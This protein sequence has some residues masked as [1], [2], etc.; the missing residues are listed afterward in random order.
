MISMT[1]NYV[2]EE[3]SFRD[4]FNNSDL[5]RFHLEL[6]LGFFERMNQMMN[7]NHEIPSAISPRIS[8]KTLVPVFSKGFLQNILLA[9]LSW[10]L[11]GFFL[12][13]V[14]KLLSS[15][16]DFIRSF[17]RDNFRDSS[18][19]FYHDAFRDSSLDS[20][21]NIISYSYRDSYKDSYQNFYRDFCWHFLAMVFPG[22]EQTSSQKLKSC[23]SLKIQSMLMKIYHYTLYTM[24]TT[25]KSFLNT[26]LWFLA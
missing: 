18:Q 15:S 20:F 17:L 9:F 5:F 19:N 14:M 8:S 16:R 13:L 23:F 2:R 22:T 1:I 26:V 10:F 12:E 3:N 21:G 24:C 7:G 11:E 4:S 25:V 6:F